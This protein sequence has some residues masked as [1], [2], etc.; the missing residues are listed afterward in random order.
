MTKIKIEDIEIWGQG[1][2]LEITFTRNFY[3]R[4][5]RVYVKV[6]IIDLEVE[7]E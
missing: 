5:T 4:K 7:K 6:P 3:G 2:Q 1:T